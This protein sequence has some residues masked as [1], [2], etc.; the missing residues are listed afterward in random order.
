MLALFLV[1]F[2]FV[3][4]LLLFCF[5]FVSFLFQTMTKHCLPC[6]SSVF[7]LCWLQGSL[8]VQLMF[9][10]LCVFLVVFVSILNYY[11]TLFGN[12]TKCFS[13]LH[14]VVL[15]PF[16]LFCFDFLRL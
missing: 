3:I 2:Y 12:K 7:E 11:C 4:V 1:C 16:L 5:C 10:L 14:I 9:L 6:N 13:C 15:F 8:F